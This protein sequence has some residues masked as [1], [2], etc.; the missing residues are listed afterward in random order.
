MFHETREVT[1]VEV[2]VNG[3]CRLTVEQFHARPDIETVLSGADQLHHRMDG[4]ALD[5]RC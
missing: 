2:H 3:R 1:A 5:E 4:H